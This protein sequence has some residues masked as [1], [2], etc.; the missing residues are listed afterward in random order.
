MTPIIMDPIP[1]IFKTTLDATQA[2]VPNRAA[3]ARE[4]IN[5]EDIIICKPFQIQARNFP[6][7][8]HN[9]LN[10]SLATST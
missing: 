10:L 3:M 5:L 1:L 6:T 8:R 9:S 2:T 7:P 4:P